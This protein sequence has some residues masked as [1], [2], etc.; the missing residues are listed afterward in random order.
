MIGKFSILAVVPAR[1]GSKGVPKKNIRNLN[2]RPL[3]QHTLDVISACEWIDNVAV[4]TDDLEIMRVVKNLGFEVPF[5]RPARLATDDT[6]DMPVLK[7]A[8]N[9]SERHFNR[10][11]DVV[12][13][14]QPTNPLRKPQDVRVTVE[15]LIDKEFDAVWTLS[16]T[17]IRFHPDKQL[18][19]NSQGVLSF[20]TKNG[21]FISARQQLK[22]TYHRNGN[23]YA[24]TRHSILNSDST[25]CANTGAVV[26][27]DIQVN[28]DSIEDFTRA[29][30]ILAS[31]RA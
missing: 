23:T 14:L 30:E 5:K 27:S 16:P 26:F 22:T 25:M 1:G 12:I 13:M 3:I 6:P 9:Q 11:F 7:H 18:N 31:I 29:E 21:R 24:F 2:G 8:L 10:K 17:D 15:L 19:L 4:S 28:I 20:C